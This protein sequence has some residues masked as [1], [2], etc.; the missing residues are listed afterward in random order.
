MLDRQLQWIREMQEALRSPWLD[1][2]FIAWN[3]VDGLYFSMTAIALTWYLWDRKIGI[4]LFYILVISFALNKILKIV[5]GQPRPCHVDPLVGILCFKTP[6]I[7]SGGAQS[8][9]IYAGIVFMHCRKVLYRVLILLFAFFL[10]FSRVYLGVHYPTDV[11]GGIGVGLALLALYKWGF[12]LFE[13][14]WKIAAIAFPFLLLVLGK[15]FSDRANW[16][17]EFF[18]ISLGVAIGLLLSVKTSPKSLP[19]RI[20]QT[21]SVIAGVCLLMA[22]QKTYPAWTFL[23]AFAEGLW[24]SFLGGWWVQVIRE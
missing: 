14:R 2:F 11:L 17:H 6:G 1:Q 21:V 8:A 23:W 7:P 22:G 5:F 16:F 15:I 18:F 4:R 20:F 3:H 13:K 12:P 9:V 10:C 24:L 19:F